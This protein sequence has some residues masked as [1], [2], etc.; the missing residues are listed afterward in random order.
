[1][2]PPQLSSQGL[3]MI[4]LFSQ[5]CHVLSVTDIKNLKHRGLLRSQFVGRLMAGF[6]NSPQGFLMVT[7]LGSLIVTPWF[8]I[9]DSRVEF[10]IGDSRVGFSIGDSSVGFSN[11]DS[12]LL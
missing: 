7:G 10:S 4:M 1:M 2:W 8:S 3:F 12:R 11:S 9:G 5:G 6:S